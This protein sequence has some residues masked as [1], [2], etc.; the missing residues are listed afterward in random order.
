M[1]LVGEELTVFGFV[2]EECEKNFENHCASGLFY[3][4]SLLR[5]NNTSINLQ[6][7]TVT[8]VGVLSHVTRA[9]ESKSEGF[10]T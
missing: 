4:W 7:F 5:N 8:V 3:S 10:S 9:V 2:R 6:M 1:I